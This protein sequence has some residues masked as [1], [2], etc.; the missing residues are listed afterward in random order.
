MNNKIVRIVL[1]NLVI[2]VVVLIGIV[3]FGQ[4]LFAA[5][6]TGPGDA[7]IPTGANMT[8]AP[9]AQTWF[10]FEY[11]GD[12]TLITATLDANGAGGIH[13]LVYTPEAI[14]RWAAGEALVNVGESGAGVDHD[15][16]WSGRI[17]VRGT[18]YVVVENLTDAA[19]DYQLRVSGE[20]VIT[21]PPVVIPTATPLPNPFAV[22]PPVTTLA[23]GKIAFQEASGGNIYTVNAD[24]T[25]LQRVTFGLDPALSP[26]GARL[27]F[28]RQGPIPG[29]WVSDA[30]GANEHILFGANE[31]RSPSWS[32]DGSRIVFSTIASVKTSEPLCFGSRCFGGG[33]AVRWRLMYYDFNE[34]KTFEISIPPTG[35]T[36]PTLNRQNNTIV[37]TNP[38]KGLMLTTFE[39]NYVSYLIDNDL[40]IK[41]P[42]VSPDGSKLTYM[43]SQP[44][45]WQVVV[46]NWDGSAPRLLTTQ[47]PLDFVHPH[48]V[49]P[50]WS[51][52]SKT[53]LF[54]SNR[55]NSD[56]WEFFAIEADGSNLRQVL[57][58]VTDQIEI[59][60]DFNAQ[61]VASWS[62]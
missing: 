20:S 52:D 50:T 34:N 45:V 26:D 43:V 32:G 27:A 57:K 51:P 7:I 10:R 19:I 40:T 28:A 44:P 35:G 38:E 58:N 18:Y 9:H 1:L 29:L 41:D 56:K 6:G 15:Q 17:N 31:V 53:I 61:R 62:K 36:L 16:V 59:H 8:V 2:G 42:V 13:F 47:D 11:G 30:N 60:Y 49:A 48:S 21:T 25:N 24:G 55:N 12:K 39:Q 46:A 4:P 3:A 33:D 14:T 54:L 5:G 37:F 22:K 23:G